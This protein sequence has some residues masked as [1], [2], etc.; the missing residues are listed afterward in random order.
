VNVLKLWKPS[1]F[2]FLLVFLVSGIPT[3]N[4]KTSWRNIVSPIQPR[5]S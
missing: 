5:Q 2:P 1:C 4:Q 3:S